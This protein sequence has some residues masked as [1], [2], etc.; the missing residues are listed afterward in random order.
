MIDIESI[1]DQVERKFRET[2]AQRKASK[3]NKRVVI[4]EKLNSD[5]F[6]HKSCARKRRFV[7]EQQAKDFRTGLKMKGTLK[8]KLRVYGCPF[9]K[10]YHLTGLVA[11]E[12]KA[13]TGSEG[14]K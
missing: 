7:S 4:I 11:D 14:Q 10:G 9:C 8:N 3:K 12:S 1:E 2:K 6:R 5:Y 13:P